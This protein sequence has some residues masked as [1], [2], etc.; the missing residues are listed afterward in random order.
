MRSA[1]RFA[2][3]ASGGSTRIGAIGFSAGG[4]LAGHAALADDA[5]ADEAVDFAVLGLRDHVDGDRER[6]GPARLIL[7]RV[8]TP[9]PELR[10]ATSLDALVDTTDDAAVFHL[11]H[12]R[13]RRTSRVGTRLPARGFASP[14]IDVPSSPHARLRAWPAH[15]LLGPLAIRAAPGQRR[16]RRATDDR[17]SFR[18]EAACDSAHGFLFSTTASSR[19]T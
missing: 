12:G 4:H 3:C 10:R 16:G 15:P 11:A 9:R 7:S 18:P 14:L 5:A 6:I 19:P 1:P 17:Q 13:G 8:R 2:G